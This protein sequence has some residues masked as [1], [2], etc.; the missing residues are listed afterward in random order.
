[1]SSNKDFLPS[2]SPISSIC[3]IEIEA[4]LLL[5]MM[6]CYKSSFQECFLRFNIVLRIERTRNQPPYCLLQLQENKEHSASP[7]R[8]VLGLLSPSPRVCTDGRTDGRTLTSEP[9]FFGSTGYQ[10]CLPMVLRELRYE[11]LLEPNGWG[12]GRICLPSPTPPLSPH[13]RLNILFVCK[14]AK[15]KALVLVEKGTVVCKKRVGLLSSKN[16]SLTVTLVII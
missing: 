11:W 2:S 7:G 8:V 12:R 3:A 10:I 1:M 4:I 15:K 14:K 13:P 5:F 6:N 16:L 9:K